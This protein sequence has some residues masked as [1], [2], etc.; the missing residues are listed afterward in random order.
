MN[1]GPRVILLRPCAAP[2]DLPS[3]LLAIVAVVVN[4]GAIPLLADIDE[5]FS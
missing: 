1:V 5:T 3:D 4:L 2:V